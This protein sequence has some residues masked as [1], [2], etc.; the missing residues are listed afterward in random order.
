MEQ[1]LKLDELDVPL[2]DPSL[3]QRFFGRLIYLT[4][5]RGN[6]VYVVH[7]LSQFMDKLY[8]PYLRAS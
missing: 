6:L 2:K 1:N 3:H 8:T 5:R 7:V 4:I